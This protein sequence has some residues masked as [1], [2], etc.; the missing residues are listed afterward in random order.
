M[1]GYNVTRSI[2]VTF[3]L[4]VFNNIYIIVCFCWGRTT[5]DMF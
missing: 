2:K 5:L 4:T 1:F 3:R